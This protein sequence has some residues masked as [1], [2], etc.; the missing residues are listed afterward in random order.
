M[1]IRYIYER[2]SLSQAFKVAISWLEN[3]W[4]ITPVAESSSLASS[5]RASAIVPAP[6]HLTWTWEYWLRTIEQKKILILDITCRSA[7]S[8]ASQCQLGIHIRML[9][10]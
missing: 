5:N 4:I 6:L 10:G 3:F 8:Q 1:K 7:T 2:Q 9:S